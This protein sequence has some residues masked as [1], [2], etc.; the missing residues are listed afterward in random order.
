MNQFDTY[1]LGGNGLSPGAYYIE[2]A[3]IA[4]SPPITA[5]TGDVSAMG[6][7]SAVA[8]VNSVGG[9]SASLIASTV[10]EVA[11]ATSSNTPSTLVE[12]DGS[13]NFSAGTITANLI[14]NVSGSSSS[15]TGSLSGD[16]TGTQGA[17]S[18]SSAVVTG[19]LLTGYVT[20]SNTP[21]TAT[22][23][24]LTA[25]E[26]LQAQV[27]A[28]S[29]SGITQ[30]TGDVSA[31]GPGSVAATVN[32]VGG[33]TATDIASAVTTV[34]AATSSNISS[35]LVKR[36]ASGNFSANIVTASLNG[37][38]NSATTSISFTGPLAGDVTGTQ[39]ATVVSFVDSYTA[40]AVGTSVATTQAATSSNAASTLVK[41]DASGN[42]SAGT[43]TAA[44]IGNVTGNVS[45][46]SAS[47]TGSLSGDVTG[48]QS[49]TSVI[50]IQGTAVNSTPP[51]DAQF[52][53]YQ[54]GITAYKA[55]SLSG[56][57]AMTDAGVATVGSVGGSSASSINSTVIEVAAAT[58][59]NVPGTL[60]LR[61]GSGNFSANII[62]AALNGNASTS[63]TA[64]SFTGSLSGDVTG[65]QGATVLS[66]T[67]NATLTTLS[68]LTTASALATVGTITSG[69]WNGTALTAPYM[70]AL[71]T[72]EIYVGN[73]SNQPAAVAMSGDVSIV[74]SGA[75]S[76]ASTT[77]T[78]KLLTGYTTGVNTPI[79][80]TNSIL[81]AFENLQAQVSGSVGSA[82][83]SLTGDV[84]ATGPGAA[85]ATV[86]ALQGSAVSSTAPTDAQLLI[87]NSGTSKW[88]PESISGDAT[89]ADTGILT[90]S[91][92]NS[93]VG[94]FG[95]S[96]AIP[97]LTVNAK[98]LITA[99]TTDP[100]I[101]P[102]GT[103]SGT[104][105]NSTV[106]SS[107]LTSVG[108]ITSG[109]WNGTAL[110]SPYMLALPSADIYVGNGSNQP[111]A[112]AMSGD[113][114]ISNTGVVT[115][116]ATA[117]TGKLLTGY[118][119]GTNTP[120]VATNTILQ[121]LE[122]LQAQVSSSVGSAITALTGD[123]T[124]TG[125]GSVVFT[126][127]TV[128]S[129][130][131]TFGSSTAIPSLTVN[132]KGLITAITTDPVVAPAG[133]LTGTTLASNVV[134][135]SL[136]SVG[137]I[138][139]GTWN[140]TTIAIANG[141]TGQTTANAA[142]NALSPMSNTGDT[143]YE[144]AP[145][146]ASALPIGTT[147]EI[148]TV[149]AGIPAWAT[150]AT[151]GTVTSVGLSLPSIFNVT[152]SPIT[153][154][155]TLTA[156]LNTEP[157]NTV[158]AGPVSGSAAVPTFRALVS[159]DIP[160]NAANTTGT[161]S[162]ITATSNSTLTTLTALSLP[163]SQ[164]TGNISGNAANVTGIVNVANGGTDLSS[165]PTNGQ[166]L[167][168]N[169]TNYT[170]ATLTQAANQGVTITNGAGSIALGTVQDIR[171]TAS[172]TFAGL[173]DTALTADG[174]VYATTGG[175]LASTAAL[176]NGQV[177]MGSTGSVPVA[178]TLTA[179]TGIS[180]TNAAGSITVTNTNTTA[181]VT[182]T[183][184]YTILSTDGTIFCDT[185]GGA[186]TLTLPSP[187]SLGG[188]LYRIIDSTG[189]FQTNNLTLAPSGSEKIEGL[190]ASKVLQTPWG[191]FNVTTN[192]TDWFVG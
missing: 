51:T 61:D 24:V 176:T 55:V 60:V 129:N 159:A 103:L 49:A 192:G 135:S 157:A 183:A 74:S 80:A 100:V 39:G 87:W 12:R 34:D 122:N 21:I 35:T 23:S 141:G 181:F 168:G 92:V 145:G 50:K 177:L 138:T 59:S 88:T 40:V 165:T 93:N 7:G 189:F 111:A 124:A 56:D 16:V 13:G 42:F 132:A 4:G 153:T 52:L 162:N 169:G 128:N 179:G 99:I 17:T 104:T 37:N 89:L 15:F 25:F 182:K 97:S 112:V 1:L 54:T 175:L 96:T 73:G 178:A 151:S 123:G 147:G 160:N 155:G 190:A 32:S 118:V 31:T 125:P 131:G 120:I 171:T 163:G 29:G 161:A 101:A 66:A 11:A 152:V 27:S 149:V 76:I 185:S 116:S 20:G 84:T 79:V 188:K 164:V 113:S 191:W 172:P 8:T 174:A 186:F 90:L 14:G 146:V 38:A 187:T 150:P 105:L 83:T 64:I 180:V 46:S 53:V 134:S 166:L 167:I 127:A 170:L 184:N 2:S 75:T 144:S 47:F 136:T 117:V 10:N 43:I 102:A 19:K 86:V 33:K 72:N 137:T 81:T 22:N 3:I 36:D 107:S 98:G 121:A 18:I 119:T 139:S 5:L 67:S 44:L 154:S 45:G 70:L 63:T 126:L 68:A 106:V 94:T 78:G 69:V 77:V 133:T 85:A 173:T 28:V 6:P 48:T 148:L 9:K 110:T 58:S 115:L 71:P 41:R 65:T 130:V 108:T 95:S 26:N 109:V 142:F 143:I 140:G 57:V 62:T 82:I 91:T 158:F 156:V 114:T 30:L